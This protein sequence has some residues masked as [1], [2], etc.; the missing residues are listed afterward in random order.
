MI[1][2]LLFPRIIQ[3]TTGSAFL[4]DLGHIARRYRHKK[5]R[6]GGYTEASFTLSESQLTSGILQDFYNMNIGARLEEITLGQVSWEGYIEEMRYYGQGVEAM[7]SVHPEHCRNRIKV[8]YS[9][10]IG[11]RTETAFSENTDSSDIFGEINWIESL[12]GTTTAGATAWRDTFLIT[13]AWP[14]SRLIGGD[15]RENPTDEPLPDELRITCKGYW[16]SIG[17]R[18]R[19]TSETANYD[20]LITTL[21]GESEFVTAGRIETNA[22]DV[23][24]DCFPVP[25]RINDLLAEIIDQGDTSGNLW[26]GGVYAGR[27]FVYEQADTDWI[28]Q[29]QGD[30]LLDR[31]GSPFPLSLVPAGFLLFSA[32]APTGWVKPGTSTAWDDPKIGYVD[33]VEYV[34]G[35]ENDELRMHFFGTPPS[36][37][38]IAKQIRRGNR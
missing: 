15:A 11:S 35:V 23:K 1:S 7:I 2:L 30:L 12:A 20:A 36:A 19:E 31:A 6:I 5:H 24:V 13:N 18:Y 26:E 22:S 29:L 4:G 27:L 3:S 37:H 14:R 17:W 16:H 8:L 38:V 25:R 28:Y 33:E 9:D 32:N 34:R 21:V 10:D